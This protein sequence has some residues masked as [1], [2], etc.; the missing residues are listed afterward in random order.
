MVDTK[1]VLAVSLA[2]ANY[3]PNVCDDYFANGTTVNGDCKTRAR[4]LMNGIQTGALSA[5]AK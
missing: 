3:D 2:V 1:L 4:A 5:W